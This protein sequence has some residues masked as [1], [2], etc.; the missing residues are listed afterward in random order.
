MQAGVHDA[1]TQS[2]E[3]WVKGVMHRASRLHEEYVRTGDFPQ[4]KLTSWS[5]P[6]ISPNMGQPGDRREA[7]N[8]LGFDTG[9]GHSASLATEYPDQFLDDPLPGRGLLRGH[10]LMHAMGQVLTEQIGLDA[11]QRCTHRLDLGDDIDA[12]AI[13]L[14]HLADAAHLALDALERRAGFLLDV[15]FQR[16]PHGVVDEYRY[17]V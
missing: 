12:I 14:D 8:V 4:D 10:C 13:I 6:E 1:R 3:Q 17:R 15:R 16:Y 2:G 11:R 7:L 5:T 9:G